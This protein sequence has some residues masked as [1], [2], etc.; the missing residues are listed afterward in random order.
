[1]IMAQDTPE[2][3]TK[4]T[5]TLPVLPDKVPVQLLP[6]TSTSTQ[7]PSS[8]SHMTNDNTK[9]KKKSRSAPR[10]SR[11]GRQFAGFAMVALPVLALITAVLVFAM[12]YVQHL[13]EKELASRMGS[14]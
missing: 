10:V 6:A 1:M 2:D 11:V 5:V 14:V 7:I 4:F 12:L 8:T 9:K 13:T 3:N